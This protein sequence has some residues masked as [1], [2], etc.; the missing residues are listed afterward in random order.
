MVDYV[1]AWE[2]TVVPWIEVQ[3]DPTPPEVESLHA[4]LELEETGIH[5]IVEEWGSPSELAVALELRAESS[6]WMGS[7]LCSLGSAHC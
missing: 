4:D 6:T 5:D 2:W 3:V 1:A 7:E